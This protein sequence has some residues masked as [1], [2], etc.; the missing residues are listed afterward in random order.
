MS[1][2][3]TGSDGVRH[4]V[5]WSDSRDDDI[6][7]LPLDAKGTTATEPAHVLQRSTA[8]DF[9]PSISPTGRQIAFSSTRSGNM[10]IWVADADGQH[11]RQVTHLGAHIVAFPTWS[12][13]ATR[14][15]FQ[16][17]TPISHIYVV[18]VNQ[19]I[20]RQVALDDQ[21]LNFAS[22]S[23]DGQFVYASSF[24]KTGSTIVR[25]PADGGPEEQLWEGGW[26]RESPDG[27][28]LFYLKRNEPGIYSRS[29]K[30]DLA[31]NPEELMVAGYE[32]STNRGGYAP[33]RG[34][35]YY[36]ASNALGQVGPFRFFDE[37]TRTSLD[38]A[39]PVRGLGPGFS[40]A[41]DRRSLV[42]T[43]RARDGGNL[44][45]LELRP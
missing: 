8:T 41:P 2:G 45:L 17:N 44:L 29:L 23:S 6:W 16:A 42:Y 5:V 14:I 33:V 30:G 24:T 18:D 19:G 21:G 3:P 26:Q 9:A 28:R 27:A 35:I 36:V 38:V 31:R 20:P 4:A 13:D 37:S 22:W 39:P 34:G 32:M 15:A 43:A 11:P 25:A 12:P 10:E 40:A 7:A 1:V